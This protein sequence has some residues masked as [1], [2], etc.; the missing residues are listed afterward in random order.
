M[1]DWKPTT[2]ITLAL[3]SQPLLRQRP[4]TA[5]HGSFCLFTDVA[6]IYC[7]RQ[8]YWLPDAN[9]RG[10]IAAKPQQRP[11]VEIT[12][13]SRASLATLMYVKADD[14]DLLAEIVALGDSFRRTLGF[15]PPAAFGQAAAHGTLLAAVQDRRVIGY[16]L[17]ALPRQVVRITH[18]CVTEA[19]R[20]LGLARRMVDAISERHADRLGITLKCRTDY[21]INDIWPH[22]GF[23]NQGEVRGRSRKRLP[24]T[25]WWRDHGHPNLFSVAEPIGLLRVAIDLNIFLDLESGADRAANFE[26]LAL[27]DDW[28]VDQVELVTTPELSR[29]LGRLPD[30]ADKRRQQR[31]ASTYHHLVADPAAA[32]ALALQITEHVF[33]TQNLDL[34][35]AAGDISDVRHVAETSLAG[36][37]VMTTR[38]AKFVDW[39][40]GVVGITGVRVMRPADV[41]L[42]IDE[43]SRAQAYRPVQLE[44]TAYRIIPVRSG[45]E[46]ELLTFLHQTDGERKPEYLELTRRISAEGRRWTREVLRSPGDKPIAFC[47][48]G[49]HDS[50]LEV[51][52]F[53]IAAANLEQTIT[54]QLLFRIRERAQREGVGIVRITDPHLAAETLRIMREDGFVGAGS[55]WILF[56]IRACDTAAA[57]NELLAGLARGVGLRLQAMQSGMSPVIAADLERKIWP[58]KI[59][60]SELPTYLIPIKPRWS[61][62]L[63][64]VPQTMTPRPHMLGLSREHVYYRSPFPVTRAPARLVWYV[65]K[66]GRD[67]MAAVI[68]CSRLDESIVSKPTVLFQRFRHLGV[69]EQEQIAKA[70]KRGQAEALR[71][72]DTEIFRHPIGLKRLQQLARTHGQTLTLRSRMK[73]TAEL[74]SAIYRE[75]R[76][77]GDG[78]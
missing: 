75:G 52:I 47:A 3:S 72:C 28:L 60:D 9:S 5:E 6:S 66:T 11:E 65:T 64:G 73:I 10:H 70:A 54:R 16:V 4:G 7:Y 68:G 25:V 19:A 61:S 1:H 55:E 20:G 46:S 45:A 36:V 27:A 8:P 51:P 14:D 37:T 78:P 58:V 18:L 53:R 21:P 39:A 67:G 41:I 59:I 38:D 32:E 44:D 40:A 62:D 2:T 33:K 26:S 15:M 76:P 34:S 74:F 50:A 77:S 42:H 49:T 17:Y 24:L 31:A 22:L 35:S 23:E 57:V 12:E 43:L 48:M 30:G 13:G 29:E 71:F 63:F 56:V 69:W